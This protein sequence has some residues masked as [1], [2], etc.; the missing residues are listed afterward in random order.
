MKKIF[1]L[2]V[3]AMT[4]SAVSAQVMKEDESALVYYSPK[5]TI[6]L[7]F[8]YTVEHFERGQYAEYADA[9]LGIS[10]IVMETGSVCT[11]KDVRVGTAVST[12]YNRPHK[13]VNDGAFPLLL[14]I[15]D[16]GLLTG[17][18]VLPLPQ[19]QMPRKE[20]ECKKH[21][22]ECPPTRVA[23]YPEEVL[24]AANPQAKAL[25]IAKQ[26]FHL[27]ETRMYLLNGEVEHA[28]ADGEA[29]KLVLEELDNQERA[30][31]ELFI[32]RKHMRHEHKTVRVEPSNEGALL[33][34]S[35]ENGFTDSDNID[36]D[37]IE[38]RML[39]QQQEAQPLDQKAKKKAQEL[40]QIVYNVPGY[41][42]VNVLYQGKSLADNKIPVAQFGIDVALPKKMFTGK[43]LPKITFSEKTG[44]IVSIS[45]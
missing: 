38:V 10:D 23:P 16:K 44:N 40:S 25:E 33:F 18:N 5:T 34:F 9:L 35:E 26:I 36:A 41:C 45:K 28:P 19:K 27:R 42:T 1:L 24:K 6:A 11:L 29:M 37:T 30:L 2:L 32:G 15:N 7:E 22:H 31:T 43:E 8:S 17:Y 39:C 12:D 4:V 14:T 13:V 20:H 3:G 21:E